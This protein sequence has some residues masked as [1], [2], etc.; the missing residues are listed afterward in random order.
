M[1]PPHPSWRLLA[2]SGAAAALG[3]GTKDQAAGFILGLGLL[4]LCLP[5]GGDSRS[6]TRRLRAAA[7]FSVSLL[8]VYALAAVA[9][10]PWRWLHHVHFVTSDHVLPETPA[11]LAGQWRLLE[12]AVSRLA[13]ILSVPG[14]AL[15]AAGLAILVLRRRY[16]EAL[17]LVLPPAAYYLSIIAR[18]RAT[19]ERYLLPIA[20]PAALCAG[21]AAGSLWSWASA[22][23]LPVR[24]VAIASLAAVLVYQAAFN[25]TPVTYCQVFDLKRELARDLPAIVPPGTPILLEDMNTFNYP[26]GN[27]Y[28]RYPLML[29]PGRAIWPTSTHPRNVLSPYTPSCRFVLAGASEPLIED[30]WQFNNLVPRRQWTYP[31]WV[32]KRVKVPAIYEFYLF[33]RPGAA[34]TA[35]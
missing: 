6:W 25:Y 10:Q 11:G 27:V 26:N 3:I 9:V 28:A 7:I 16:R 30:P 32:S 31:E 19:E 20:L 24:S 1:P 29:A 4:L 17:A 22:R 2:A 13:G 15:G 5:A 34:A 18:V 21:V 35:R 12:R 14:L 33:E 23:G 8:L